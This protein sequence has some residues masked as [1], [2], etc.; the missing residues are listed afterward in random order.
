MT[1]YQRNKERLREYK[2]ENMRRYRAANPERY[3]AHSRKAKRKL[4]L[5]VEAVFG[6]ACVL[7]GFSDTRA[8]TLDHILN[9]GAQERAELGERGVYLRAIKPEHRH[10]YRILCMNCQFIARHGAGRQNQHTGPA[11]VALAWR[12]LFQDLI[13]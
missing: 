7:C 3:A 5:T 1:Y 11:V 8:L 9:N 6:T 10:E 4:R 12:T 13:P 2:K